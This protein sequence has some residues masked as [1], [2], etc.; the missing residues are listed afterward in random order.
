M[1]A[2]DDSEVGR[3]G[4]EVDR[5][6]REVEQLRAQAEDREQWLAR[7][8]HELRAPLASIA[9]YVEM[10]LDGALGDLSPEQARALQ[11]VGRN[12]ERLRALVAELGSARPSRRPRPH[13]GPRPARRGGGRPGGR[14]PAPAD[15]QARGRA[16][17]RATAEPSAARVR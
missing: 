15:R 3:P 16:A 2:G 9:G 8:G 4:G 6:R 12:A 5:A 17:R 14:R 10:L 1:T 7:L 11:V 13:P